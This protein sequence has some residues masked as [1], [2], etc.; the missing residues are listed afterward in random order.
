MREGRRERSKSEGGEGRR[1][2]GREGRGGRGEEGRQRIIT[3]LGTDTS[4][5]HRLISS[6]A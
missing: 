3:L 6:T 4:A 5:R 1:A 2:K